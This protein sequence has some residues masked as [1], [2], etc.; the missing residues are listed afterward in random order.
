MIYAELGRYPIQ[1][2]IDA[3]MIKFWNKIVIG[4]QNKMSYYC[5]QS[6]NQS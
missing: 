2:T 5:Y 1:I 4:K 6:V 3:R